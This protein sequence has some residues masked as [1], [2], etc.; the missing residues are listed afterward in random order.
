MHSK[1][2]L[3]VALNI[4][5]SCGIVFAN[6]LVLSDYAFRFTVTLTFIHTL[7]TFFGMQLLASLR[8][9]ETKALP[10]AKVFPLAAAF[11][12]YIVLCN[13]S[14]QINPISFYQVMKIAVAPTVVMVEAVLFKKIPTWSTLGA[15]AVVCLGVGVATVRDT[16]IMANMAGLVVGITATVVTAMYQV[17]VGSK[18][19]EL[20]ADS[21]QLLQQYTPQASFILALLIPL[22]DPI[23]FP[24]REEGTLLAYKFTL[25]SIMAIAVSTVL[26]LLVSVSTFLVIGATSSLTYNIVGHLKTVVILTGGCLMFGDIMTMQKLSG[27]LVSMVGIVWYTQLKSPQASKEAPKT[28]PRTIFSSTDGVGLQDAAVITFDVKDSLRSLRKDAK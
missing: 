7:F 23:G 10:A 4:V 21:M 20:Q 1:A 11:V 12:A 13:L 18:Q 26:G 14:L 16:A 22:C 24:N 28:L 25:G 3:Y 27:I 2:A 9:Y 19:K 5:S 6:K 17:W 8:W 15:V